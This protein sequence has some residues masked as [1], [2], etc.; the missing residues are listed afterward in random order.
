MNSRLRGLCL[1]LALFTLSFARAGDDADSIKKK[2]QR[3]VTFEFV[4]T[5]LADAIEFLR[6]LTNVTIVIDPK[7]ME[8]KPAPI[9]LRVTDMQM[10][11]ALQWILKLAELDYMV[12]DGAIYINTPEAIKD[13]GLADAKN[14]KQQPDPPGD[15]ILRA[16]FST[17]DQI[18]MDA[19]MMK[20]QP[21]L[22]REVLSMVFDPAKDE[23]LAL[24]MGR[25]IPPH[26]PVE[27]FMELAKKITPQ[28]TLNYDEGLKLLT[29]TSNDEGDLHKLN[30]VARA[31]RKTGGP[32]ED[33][34]K[35]DKNK[36]ANAEFDKFDKAQAMLNDQLATLKG[37]LEKN[38]A[39][40][41][42]VEKIRNEM[43]RLRDM[44]MR[45]NENR[46]QAE[47]DMLI[48]RKE[49]DEKMGVERKRAELQML[50]ERKNLEAQV[51]ELRNNMKMQFDDKLKAI[52]IEKFKQDKMD[53]MRKK[54]M[55]KMSVKPPKPPDTVQD[56]F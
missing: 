15:G 4:D 46:K 2:L 29:I 9:N 51:L 47:M 13:R 36:A 23:I 5:P 10:D 19:S 39:E 6:Q 20:K 11:A 49:A 52:E 44:E 33:F 8:K 3:K 50:D 43:T 25:D 16:R 56:Q 41:A 21:D 53:E 34:K 17:G 55:E 22:A 1:V 32:K 27:R 40:P 28:A 38:V 18:E 45:I 24:V 37:A 7:V 48:Q 42:A 12:A 30:A 14:K 35:E 26:I 54:V 31:L